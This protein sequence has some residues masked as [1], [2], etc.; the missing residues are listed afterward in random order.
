VKLY[1]QTQGEP[2]VIV[3]IDSGNRTAGAVKFIE[4][5]GAKHTLLNDPDGKV[6]DAY[7]VAGIPTTV[8]VDQ[9]GR[10]MFRHVG[11]GEGM[12]EQFRKEIETLLAWGGET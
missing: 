6:F 12:E 4:D 10:L 8:V 5:N 11:F 2:V 7:G 1:E 9:A 3:S